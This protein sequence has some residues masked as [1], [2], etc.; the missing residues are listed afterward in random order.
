MVVG[1]D[2]VQ[3]S[4]VALHV[5]QRERPVAAGDDRASGT[6]VLG[7]LRSDRLFDFGPRPVGPDP[8]GM[9]VHVVESAE[10]NASK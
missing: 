5:G 6:T 7:H 9:H 10:Q 8:L 4:L 2:Q 1:R 3:L